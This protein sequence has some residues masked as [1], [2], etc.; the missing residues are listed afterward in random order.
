MGIVSD[1]YRR[2]SVRRQRS[3][4]CGGTTSLRDDNTLVWSI[5]SPTTTVFCI[6]TV[7]GPFLEVNIGFLLKRLQ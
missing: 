2:W 6:A 3:H 4:E 5:T 1:L 7:V